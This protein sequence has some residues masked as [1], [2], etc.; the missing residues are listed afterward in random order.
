MTEADPATA[1]ENAEQVTPDAIM[2]LGFAFWGSKALLSAIELKLFHV[3]CEGG[4]QGSDELRER[5]GLRLQLA[6]NFGEEL[7]VLGRRVAILGAAADRVERRGDDFLLAP[8]DFVLFRL[9]AAT[10]ATTALLRL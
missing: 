6:L 1:V 8:R 5:L 7:A 2:Q 9:A 4:P 3:L 10:A